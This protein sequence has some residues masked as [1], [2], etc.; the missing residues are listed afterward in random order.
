MISGRMCRANLIPYDKFRP[1]NYQKALEYMLFISVLK[2]ER[3][4]FGDEKHLEGSSLWC[5]RVRR[6]VLTGEVPAIKTHPD[7]RLRYTIVGFC[8]IDP[9]VTPVRYGF[10][11]NTNDAESFSH[12]VLLAIFSG[13]LLYG[14][15][16]VLDNATIHNGGVNSDLENWLWS[17]F[18]IFLLYLPARTPE[19]NPIELVWN[20]LVQRLNVFC[21]NLAKELAQVAQMAGESSHSLVVAS[22]TVLDNISHE[23]VRGCYRKSG[24][25]V[26]K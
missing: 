14:D 15:I 7:F 4:K 6:S 18:R 2:P 16:L 5:R 22:R 1:D 25:Q 17:N 23:E 11:L 13:W 3:I 12:H 9:R 24:Y 8:G 10:T 20:I 21:L 19:W 26:P